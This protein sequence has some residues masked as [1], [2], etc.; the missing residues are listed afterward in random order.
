MQEY[1]YT[2]TATNLPVVKPG[3]FQSSLSFPD[4]SC[5]SHDYAV[6]ST[7]LFPGA[8]SNLRWHLTVICQPTSHQRPYLT[9]N[10]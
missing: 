8:A 5:W 9:G 10:Q 6:V 4:T 1:S 3:F 7:S 2:E